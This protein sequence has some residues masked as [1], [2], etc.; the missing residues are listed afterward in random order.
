MY[1]Q[2]ANPR[3]RLIAILDPQD[4]NEAAVNRPAESA[5]TSS[6]GAAPVGSG[7]RPPEG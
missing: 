5:E 3:V 2:A 1:L 6:L 7:S 4:G